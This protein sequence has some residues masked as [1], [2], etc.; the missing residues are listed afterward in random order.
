MSNGALRT[1]P[2]RHHTR[3]AWPIVAVAGAVL[4]VIAGVTA[5]LLRPGAGGSMAAG[6]LTGQGTPAVGRPTG[7][8]SHI[9][10]SSTFRFLPLWPFPSQATAAAWQES[11][12][13]EGQ[14]PWHRDA[15]TTAL[16]FSSGY[17]GYSNITRVVGTPTYSTSG[18]EAWVTVGG[19][20]GGKSFSAAVVHLVKFGAEA[21]APWEAVGTQDTTL[22]VSTPAY[23]SSVGSPLTVSGRITGVDESITVQVLTSTTRI[24]KVGGV[25]AG[26]NSAA[27][28]A[29]V[30]FTAVTGTTL[31]VAVATGGH[32]AAVERF[33]V[34]GVQVGVG[35]SAHAAKDGDIDGDGLVDAV[36]F[37][38]PDTLKVTYGNGGTDTV[39]FAVAPGN[40]PEVLG[41]VDADADGDAEVFVR[42]QTDGSASVATLFRYVAGHLH[43]VTLDGEQARLP[44]GGNAT[45]QSSW[46]C[47]QPSGAIVTW[48]GTST[49]GVTFPGT[50]NSYQFDDGRLVQVT[51]WSKTVTEAS[52]APTGCGSIKLSQ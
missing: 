21:D 16:S 24:G 49:D 17:L 40:R 9:G 26:G 12:R 27:W 50:L 36:R 45:E 34:T 5:L 1:T 28:A 33:A 39:A 11:Y 52:P 37:P 14:Q 29:Q 4:L 10:T 18:N 7:L 13:S 15:G 31:A 3:Q 46:A 47:Q 2:H 43:L 41:I 8:S 23:W 44:Y 32:F 35:R 30:S 6:T 48:T 25:P 22:T 38:T 20:H 42:T 19:V 51:T